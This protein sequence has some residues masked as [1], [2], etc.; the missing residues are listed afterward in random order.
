MTKDPVLFSGQQRALFE[1]LMER[2]EQLGNMYIGAVTV[3]A[4]GSNPERLVLAAHG[5]RELMEKIPK[6]LHIKKTQDTLKSRTRNLEIAWEKACKNSQCLK[7]PDSTVQIDP[8]LRSF[9][10]KMGE[11]FSW[12][13]QSHPKR[14]EEIAKTLQAL[15]SIDRPLPPPIKE[16]RVDEWDGIHDYF[17]GVAHHQI[18]P[19]YNDFILW[20]DVIERFLLDRLRPRTFADFDKIDSIIKEGETSA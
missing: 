8:P 11:F 14:K 10:R 2:N 19:G 3:L 6:Y 12:F 1:A 16:L 4:D 18:N 9:L 13:K 20:L 5:L 15:D 7:N 17:E